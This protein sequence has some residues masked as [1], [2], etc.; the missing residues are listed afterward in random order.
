MARFRRR[1][2]AL[3][4]GLSEQ[5]AARLRALLVGYLRRRGRGA[6]RARA[7]GAPGGD[8]GGRRAAGEASLGASVVSGRPIR[9]ARGGVPAP[10]ATGYTNTH[11][12]FEVGNQIGRRHGV[13]AR[14]VDDE[15][16]EVV[17]ALYTPELVER[18]PAMAF[19][20]CADVGASS[21]CVGGHRAAGHG[22]RGRRAAPVAAYL[23]LRTIGPP[24]GA[25]RCSLL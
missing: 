15:A 1:H 5:D 11:P 22:P 23:N 13:W 2:D 10:G 18:Y 6:G 25:A 4:D 16:A 8:A 24:L 9:R 3:F 20:G 12:P 14:D 19:V 21:P 17:G 7:G